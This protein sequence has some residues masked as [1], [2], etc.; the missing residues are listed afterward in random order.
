MK[1]TSKTDVLHTRRSTRHERYNDSL[2]LELSMMRTPESASS[3]LEC[4]TRAEVCTL[5]KDSVEIANETPSEAGCSTTRG[6]GLVPW[7]GKKVKT[8]NKCFSFLEHNFRMGTD[9]VHSKHQPVLASAHQ[10][11]LEP[12]ERFSLS[13]LELRSTCRR[14]LPQVR[15]RRNGETVVARVIRRR[16]G[17]RQ[18]S[19][20]LGGTLGHRASV[21][22]QLLRK[23]RRNAM[24]GDRKRV[25]VKQWR[26]RA[27][28]MFW[29]SLGD[30]A[31]RN[32]TFCD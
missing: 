26:F 20:N 13:A 31:S 1:G 30:P 15:H 24:Y 7:S 16:P 4:K 11:S 19:G 23:E 12:R 9:L 2:G 28:R 5:I 8:G 22:V 29:E 18:I 6:E 17:G 14:L 32:N 10:H 3:A 21:I 25:Y 27:L